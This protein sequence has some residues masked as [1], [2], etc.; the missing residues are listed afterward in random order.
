LRDVLLGL[1]PGEPEADLA[2]RF[3][4]FTSPV[5]AKGVEDTAFYRYLRF[6]CLNEVGGDPRRFGTTPEAFHR[7]NTTTA[8]AWPATM[9]TTSTHDTKRSEDVRA[10]LALLSEIPEQWTLA[11]RRWAGRNDERRRGG[12]PD[13]DTEYLVYQ[14]LVGAWPIDT[15]RAVAY[16]LKAV[17]EAKRH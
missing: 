8:E 2:L 4:Q 5:I 12:W 9:L 3:Q 10:R 14:T 1:V 17:K 6:V 16:V 13:A 15:E 11:V 7:H